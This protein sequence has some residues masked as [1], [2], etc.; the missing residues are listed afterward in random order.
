MSVKDVII[1]DL[2]MPDED[3]YTMMSR[4]RAMEPELGGRIPALALSAFATNESKQRALESG[5]QLYNTKPFEP[6]LI[7]HD[8]RALLGRN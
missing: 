2:A 7:V 3:G 6:D 4:I 1:S 5:F 8:I